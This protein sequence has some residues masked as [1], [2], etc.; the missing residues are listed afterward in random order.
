MTLKGLQDGASAIEYEWEIGRESTDMIVQS[1]TYPYI[2]KNRYLWEGKDGLIWEID[3]F[4]GD[5]AGMI[6][7]EVELEH[8][9]SEIEV[10]SWVGMELTHLSGW[11][12]AALA[13]ML[14]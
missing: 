6:I 4:E 7:A 5:L 13:R 9:D 10:P 8:V 1:A 2:E 11:S 14:T 3:E 12:N